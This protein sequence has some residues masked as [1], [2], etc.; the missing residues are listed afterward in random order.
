MLNN[1]KTRETESECKV[2]R[3]IIVAK[4]QHAFVGHGSPIIGPGGRNQWQDVFRGY[5]CK[6]C[7]IKYEFLPKQREKSDEEESVYCPS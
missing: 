4:Y 1:V 3:G 2:C 5:Y 7:G 6:G